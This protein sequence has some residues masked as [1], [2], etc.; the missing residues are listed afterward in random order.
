MSNSSRLKS[1]YAGVT[2]DSVPFFS[3][4]C[5]SLN[6]THPRPP[7]SLAQKD[8]PCKTHHRVQF[9]ASKTS[10]RWSYGRSS[11]TS[12]FLF[13]FF[14]STNQNIHSRAGFNTFIFHDV[15]LL[16]SPELLPSY[17]TP[18][19]PNPIHIARVWSRYSNNA[20]YFGGIVSFSGDSFEKLNG[21]PNN[22]WGWGG[23][24]DELQVSA[25]REMKFKGLHRY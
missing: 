19:P 22:F 17:T 3:Y 6:N 12:F 10:I 8:A 20:K 11:G 1:P 23:E 16:P 18:A 4:R 5:P 7:P 15:D 13:C 2:A 9:I 21:F 14:F 25:S 24:D